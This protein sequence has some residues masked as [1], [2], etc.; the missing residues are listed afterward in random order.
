MSHPTAVVCRLLLAGLALAASPA[1]ADLLLQGHALAD[2]R[3]A[4]LLD[5]R[6][7]LPD[8]QGRLERAADGSYARRDGGEIVVAGGR[9]TPP[10]DARYDRPAPR[11]ALLTSLASGETVALV[12]GEL[13]FVERDGSRRPVPDGT[14]HFRNGAAAQV[15]GGRTTALGDLSGFRQVDAARLPRLAS[16]APDATRSTE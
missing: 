2:G 5:N 13:H 11:L 1:A 7:Y 6:L 16:P 9:A 14:Y 4:V 3:L 15:R 8:A 12:D 10:R